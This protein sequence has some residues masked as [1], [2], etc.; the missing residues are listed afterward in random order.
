MQY[1]RRGTRLVAGQ[2]Q[3]KDGGSTPYGRSVQ[4]QNYPPSATLT[5]PGSVTEGSDIVLSLANPSDP[6]QADTDAGFEYAFDCGDGNGYSPFSSDDTTACPTYDDGTTTVQAKIRDKDD[7]VSEY[8]VSVDV[9]NGPPSING[10]SV[11]QGSVGG[12]PTTT[13]TVRFTVSDPAAEADD[14]ITGSIDWGD[15]N[16]TAISGRALNESHTYVP[17]PYSVGITVNDGD[18]GVAATTATVTATSASQNTTSGILQPINADN[19]STFKLGSVIPTKLRVWDC[20][21]ASV[22]TLALD[23]DLKRV[24]AITAPVNEVISTSAA[25]VGDLMRYDT[26]AKQYIFNLSTKRS[27]FNAGADLTSGTYELR[28]TNPSISPVVV[29]FNLKA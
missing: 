14:P 19:T 12:C 28:I 6:S 7:G 16:T 29:K 27:Q 1:R 21:G 23:V 24:S 17:G 10:L 9:L 13:T 5:A 8:G 2:I 15:G 22:G 3:D 18:G 4:V 26:S 25:D 11:T 20:N